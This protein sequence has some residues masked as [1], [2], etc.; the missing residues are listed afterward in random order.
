MKQLLVI[1]MACCLT[2]LANAE[3][4]IPNGSKEPMDFRGKANFTNTEY[5]KLYRCKTYEELKAQLPKAIKSIS[6]KKGAEWEEASQI[7]VVAL[8]QLALIRVHYILGKNKR[9]R[10][11]LRGIELVID[12][13]AAS[14]GEFNPQRLKK[15]I[16]Y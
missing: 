6:P 11:K 2:L 3:T 9:P 1:I 14:S 7:N 15:L 13:D 16:D 12:R 5:E 4:S 8:C 10:S